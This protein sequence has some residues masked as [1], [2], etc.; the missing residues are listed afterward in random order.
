ML[1]SLKSRNSSIM[2]P[3]ATWNISLE[4]YHPY[5]QPQEVSKAPT[6][7][8]TYGILSKSA[9]SHFG[10]LRS[11]GVKSFSWMLVSL[12]PLVPLEEMG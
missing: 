7:L 3:N 9:K 4:S 2:N 12:V 1:K 5:L 6:I 8:G 11:L 10:S